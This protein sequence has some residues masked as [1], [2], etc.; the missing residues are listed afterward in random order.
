MNDDPQLFLEYQPLQSLARDGE[1]SVYHHDDYW[2]SMDTYRDYLALN[3]T[4]K[5]GNPPWRIWGD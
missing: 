5:E 4:W 3:N 2:H 1:L